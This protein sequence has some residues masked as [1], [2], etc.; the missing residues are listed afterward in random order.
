MTITNDR[1]C[2]ET[3][4]RIKKARYVARNVE[5]NQ[6]FHFSASESKLKINYIYNSS[7]FGS[8]LY[9][10]PLTSLGYATQPPSLQN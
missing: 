3:D 10:S 1:N 5:L 9:H 2:L 7:W 4:M 6:E 8:T